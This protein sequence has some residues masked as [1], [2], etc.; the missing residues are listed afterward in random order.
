M[1]ELAGAVA[2]SAAA[3]C[4]APTATGPAL[5]DGERT[6][7]R[8]STAS[9]ERDLSL[10]DDH[11]YVESNDTIR[12]PARRSGGETAS[13]G[14]IPVGEWLALQ[15]VF[16]AKDAVRDRLDAE[17]RSSRWLDIAATG[18][19]GPET[20]V[21]VVHATYEVADGPDDEPRASAGTVVTT[22]P[23]TVDVTVELADRTAS[24]TYPVFVRKWV[25]SHLGGAPEN[26]T[27]DG[28]GSGDAA[29][30]L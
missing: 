4:I 25:G 11:T 20:E 16:V 21:E 15:A 14:T 18:R 12:Y 22:A 26:E 8:G 29:L 13:H 5:D 7:A 6:R 30:P 9:V 27:D 24:G 3:G 1:L 28:E 17:L 10:D 23:R 19:G 2:A